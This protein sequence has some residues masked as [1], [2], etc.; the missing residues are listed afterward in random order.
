MVHL[1]WHLLLSLVPLSSSKSHLNYL[2]GFKFSVSLQECSFNPFRSYTSFNQTL[3]LKILLRGLKK[4]A[5]PSCIL[6]RSFPQLLSRRCS[7]FP[8]SLNSQTARRI[9]GD[10]KSFFSFKYIFE[11]I[12]FFISLV[13]SIPLFPTHSC[14]HYF[15]S[16]KIQLM[17]DWRWQSQ[18]SFA[19]MLI[20]IASLNIIKD[21]SIDL[22]KK[23]THLLSL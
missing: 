15:L 23:S 5:K 14:R 18:H 19:T 13:S 16:F 2:F 11:L 12:C 3:A 8:P 7:P 1:N 9:Q 17:I 21:L 10:N 22:K 20:G 4:S 6:H